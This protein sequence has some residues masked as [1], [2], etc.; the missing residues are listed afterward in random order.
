MKISIIT[1]T[2]NS[3]KHLKNVLTSIHSQTF[4]EIEHVVVDGGS[5]DQTLDILKELSPK[6]KVINQKGKGIYDAINT[7]IQKITG[8]YFCILNSD[9]IFNKNTTLE[10]LGRLLEKDK[11][12][13]LIYG[14]LVY[15]NTNNEVIRYWVAQNLSPGIGKV[16]P[17]PSC[18]YKTKVFK[19]IVYSTDFKISGDFEFLIRV[20]K[21]NTIHKFYLNEIIVRMSIG[22]ISNKSLNNYLISLKEDSKILKN[23]RY[24]FPV[25]RALLKKLIKLKQ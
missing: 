12:I 15:V 16:P 20:L 6:S 1:P 13:D 19:K 7:G 2:L 11:S 23:H 22:G 10:E 21:D 8:E 24:N 9:D 18:F 4:G 25:L 3:E 5:S 14:D 17:H